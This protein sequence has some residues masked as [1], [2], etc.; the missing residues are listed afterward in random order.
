M[1]T[2]ETVGTDDLLRSILLELQ[3]LNLKLERQAGE[4]SNNE[5]KTGDVRD[6]EDI[7]FSGRGLFRY[8]KS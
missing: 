6:E 8:A 7:G 5:V 3:K 4:P 2:N 1:A